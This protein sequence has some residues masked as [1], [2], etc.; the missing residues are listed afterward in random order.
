MTGSDV[1][2]LE[3]VS[4]STSINDRYATGRSLPSADSSQDYT[5]ASSCKI[6]LPFTLC[7]ILAGGVHVVTRDLD[8]G[9]SSLD[10]VIADGS[11]DM[12]YAWGSST[13]LSQH[14][15]GNRGFL[16]MTIDTSGLTV[17]FDAASNLVI[18]CIS[19]LALVVIWI[20]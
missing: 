19:I 1:F 7:F 12:I 17:S 16:T 14:D 15:S 13:S 10:T 5:L 3:D 8:T 2:T 20:V 11:N 9:D 18:G 6:F 4:G